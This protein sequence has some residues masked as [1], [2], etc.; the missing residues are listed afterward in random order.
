MDGEINVS[1]PEKEPAK[2]WA[3]LARYEKNHNIL[4]KNIEGL[5][6]RMSDRL[7]IRKRDKFG[8]TETLIG[9]ET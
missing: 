7:I 5:D 3:R 1:L 8:A 4:G 9:Q 2:A 6:L